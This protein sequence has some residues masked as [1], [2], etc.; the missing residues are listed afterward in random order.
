M[1]IKRNKAK[2]L[3]AQASIPFL[4]NKEVSDILCEY[5]VYD[6]EQDIKNSIEEG[7]L[8]ILEQEAISFMARNTLPD[9]PDRELFK[10]LIMDMQIHELKNV[11]NSFLQNKLTFLGCIN[12]NILGEPEK[13][14]ICPCCQ[15]YSIDFGDEGLWDICPVCCWENGGDGPNHISLKEAQVNFESIGAMDKSSLKYVDS[16]GH[17]K[18]ERNV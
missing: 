6:S 10:P 18:Y 16:E 3:I 17:L 1:D 2:E 5:W 9:I 8:P 15:Y 14:G 13:A 4:S 12:A 11:R 7:H